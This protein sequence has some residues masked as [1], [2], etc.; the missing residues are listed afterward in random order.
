[1]G[2]TK[3][4][5]LHVRSAS[6]EDVLLMEECRRLHHASPADE[7]MTAYFRGLHHP[8]QALLP[9]IGYIALSDKAPVGYSAGHLTTRFGY[10]GELQYLFVA[11]PYRRRGIGRRL[12]QELARWFIA[13]RAATVCVCVDSE[14][15]AAAPFYTSLGAKPFKPHW[16]AWEDIALA[17]G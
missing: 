6:V 14:S 17:A 11:Q 10:T 9:R 7:R 16:Y 5:P 2:P 4:V 3:P 12:V 8:Q 15:E 13:Q 1:M